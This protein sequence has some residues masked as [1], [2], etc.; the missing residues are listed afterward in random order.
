[1]LHTI[2]VVEKDGQ[3]WFAAVDTCKVLGLRNPTMAMRHLAEAERTL[4]R[5]EGSASRSLNLISESGLYK[6]IMRSDKPVAKPF[7][8]WVTRTVLPAIRKDEAYIASRA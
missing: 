3:P 6:L 7:Q 4:N 1:M 2:R 8:D 5:I